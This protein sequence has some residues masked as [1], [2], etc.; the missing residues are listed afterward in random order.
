[1]KAASIIIIA[2][3]LAGCSS[4]SGSPNGEFVPPSTVNASPGG[5]WVGVDSD[6]QDVIALV[7]EDGLFYF[8]DGRFETGV[9]ILTVI[10]GESVHGIFQPPLE[11]GFVYQDESSNRDCK[12]TGSVTERDFMTLDVQCRT[13]EN[14]QVLTT[15]DLNYDIRYERDSTLATIAGDYG[16][17]PG[18]IL[19]I[20]TIG[21]VFGQDS[22]TGRVINGQI[23]VI[24]TSFNLYGVEWSEICCVGQDAELISKV[25]SG[26][27]LLDNTVVPEQLITAV[28]T[29]PQNRSTVLSIISFIERL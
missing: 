11:S 5:F 7:S 18:M 28:S 16:Y 14:Q 17:M 15:L 3:A 26:F 21:S 2:S 22:V 8:L 4:G 29:N 23:T 25:F 10:N 24:N 1:L 13:E 20:D 19:S 6:D 9:G 27:A 12:L